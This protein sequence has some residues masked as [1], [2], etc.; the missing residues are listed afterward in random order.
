MHH[1]TQRITKNL[2]LREPDEQE[3]LRA[4]VG[5]IGADLVLGQFEP[6]YEP[7]RPLGKDPEGAGKDHREN[8]VRQ[9]HGAKLD[10]GEGHDKR[11]GTARR[12]GEGTESDDGPHRRCGNGARLRTS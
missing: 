11:G 8:E 12:G 1:A 10:R 9:S 3:V 6:P 4:D 2:G 5:V 7:L